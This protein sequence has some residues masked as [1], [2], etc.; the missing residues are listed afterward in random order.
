MPLAAQIIGGLGVAALLAAISILFHVVLPDRGGSTPVGWPRWATCTPDQ[1]LDELR[2]G[3][4]RRAE[5]LCAMSRIAVRKMRG[6]RQAI[7]CLRGGIGL[8][9]LA[10]L[11]ARF[12]A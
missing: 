4:Q 1:I 3:Q 8:L 5:R 11:T 9:V 7:H 10:A 2:Q 12:L 6:I